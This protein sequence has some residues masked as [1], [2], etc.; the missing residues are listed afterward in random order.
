MTNETNGTEISEKQTDTHDSKSVDSEANEVDN[1]AKK[2]LSKK[3]TTP[4]VKRDIAWLRSEPM[5]LCQLFLQTESA[6]A[7]V[8]QFGSI[9]MIE[10][11]DLNPDVNAF[12]RKFVNELRRCNEMERQLGIH[13]LA[14]SA[15][16]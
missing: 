3:L 15:F 2:K 6:Y 7:C 13:L 14:V 5:S 10:F 11:R 1:K 8:D 12:Q 16:Q 4:D 9:G